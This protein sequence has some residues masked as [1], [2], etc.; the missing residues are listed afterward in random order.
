[1]RT[2]ER[3]LENFNLIFLTIMY[4]FGMKTIITLKKYIAAAIKKFCHINLFFFLFFFEFIS[5][6]VSRYS[7]SA[8][9]FFFFFFI[10]AESLINTRRAVKSLFHLSREEKRC[11]SCARTRFRI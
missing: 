2:A 6:D 8:V 3:L 5:S 11:Q 1:M 9:V 10:C 4:F 7:R